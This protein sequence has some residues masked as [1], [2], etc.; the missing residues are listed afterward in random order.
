MHPH[1]LILPLPHLGYL[2]NGDH[3]LGY[4]VLSLDDLSERTLPK[5]G[6]GVFWAEF[7]ALGQILHA[8]RG[9]L[10]GALLQEFKQL[11]G[12]AVFGEVE[13]ALEAV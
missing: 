9:G 10:L 12:C 13:D 4:L 7:V 3:L 5:H 2:F 8:V 11:E 6:C 1:Y